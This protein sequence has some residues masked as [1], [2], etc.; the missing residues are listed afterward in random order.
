MLA[1]IALAALAV[2][3]STGL[4]AAEESDELE[5]VQEISLPE[6]RN[7]VCVTMSRDG[8]FL[9]ATGTAYAIQQGAVVIFKRDGDTGKLSLA[10]T[11]K[12]PDLTG[13]M[14]IRLSSDEQFAAVADSYGA[15]VIVFKRNVETGGLT[16]LATAT[17]ELVDITDAQFS[18]DN[19]FV[20]TVSN[21]VLSV[22][23]FEDQQL[24]MVQSEKMQ[25][26]LQALRPFVISPDGHWLYAICERPGTIILFHRNESSGKLEEAQKL[27]NAQ[28]EITTLNGA[29][30][31]TES[32][33]GRFFYVSAGRNLGDQAVTAFTVQPDGQLKLLQQF[34]NEM[35]DF[36]GFEG[37]NE[38][39]VS[40]DGKWLFVLASVS[41][42]FFRFSRD[43]ETGKLTFVTSQ[44]AGVFQT[45]GAS[46]VTFSPDSKYVY[47]ADPVENAVQVYKMR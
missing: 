26:N 2:F 40:P 7:V 34:V 6:L 35:D 22:F 30:R 36:T 5:T 39:K 28:E 11:V 3:L 15:A 44:Q 37:G 31:A 45:G 25:K 42:R 14:R 18:P 47:I 27:S 43:S 41:D 33:D 12:P 19:H 24:T 4:G 38:I 8:K 32:S 20:Y 46:G 17:G 9:Y 21:T 1:Y 29:F 23:K 16:K 10:N 13:P